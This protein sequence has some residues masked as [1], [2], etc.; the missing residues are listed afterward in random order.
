MPSIQHRVQNSSCHIRVNQLLVLYDVFDCF[1]VSFTGSPDSLRNSEKKVIV[2]FCSDCRKLLNQGI[3]IFTIQTKKDSVDSN[4]GRS[5]S[6]ATVY[7]T[8]FSKYR[9]LRGDEYRFIQIVANG[10]DEG[11]GSLFHDVK[12]LTGVILLEYVLSHRKAFFMH[13]F[14]YQ[15]LFIF[16]QDGKRSFLYQIVSCHSQYL[17]FALG[18]PNSISGLAKKS[19]AIYLFIV[20]FGRLIFAGINAI[21]PCRVPSTSDNLS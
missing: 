19:C 16:I 2:Q 21:A 10:L 18:C 3:K 15:L 11:D 14:H 9:S 6:R 17:S 7:E 20:P 8:E 5:R 1:P 4:K 13:P 12:P